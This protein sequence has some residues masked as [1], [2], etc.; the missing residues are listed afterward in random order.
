M[1]EL[2]PEGV[3]TRRTSFKDGRDRTGNYLDPGPNYAWS[4]D[5]H[6]KY[7]AYRIKVYAMVHEY[8]HYV[9]SIFVGLS[10]TCGVS[11]L[12]K[13]LSAAFGNSNIRPHFIH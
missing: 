10:A 5:G 1:K 2:N 13:Y 11:I 4:V 7:Q 6:M 3:E 8:L 9:T 12:K